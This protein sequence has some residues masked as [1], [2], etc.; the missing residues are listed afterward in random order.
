MFRHESTHSGYSPSTAP[1]ANDTLLWQWAGYGVF[2]PIVVDGKVITATSSAVYALD[3]TTGVQVWGPTTLGGSFTASP[4]VVGDRLYL[5]TSAGFMYCINA[6]TGEE[7]WEYQVTSP[8]QIQASPTVANG[9]VYFGTTN[10][11][12]YALD[13][14]TGLYKWRYTTGNSIY[15]S[16]PAVEGTMIYFGCDDGKLYAINDTGTLPQKKWDFPTKGAIECTPMLADGKVFCGSSYNDHALFAL[17]KT[18]G[19][20]IWKF[21]TTQSYAIDQPPAFANGLVFF[22]GGYNKAYALYSNATAGNY[23]ENDPA[24]QLWGRTTDYN[25][26]P[27]CVADN[28]VFVCANQDLFALNMST[29]IPIWK[30]NFATSAYHAVV[31]DGRLFVNSYNGIICFGNPFPPETYHY[32]VNAGG[33][34]W[35]VKLVLNATPSNRLNTGGLITLKK[36]SYNVTGISGTVGMSNITIPNA[37]LGGPYTVTVDGGLPSYSAAPVDNGTHTSLYFTYDHSTHLIEIT[38]TTVIPEA[39]PWAILPLL[40]ATSLIAF[41]IKKKK[42]KP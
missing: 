16:S 11:Y 33:Q 28:K 41:A 35:D 5:G 14:I 17:D 8:G 19:Q 1:N 22:S 3:E 7:I 25:G 34:D 4:T 10:N 24:I 15:S 31:A 26:H 2:S 13:A 27:P 20:L 21:E 39:T 29:G 40:A 42:L 37:L 32:T 6:T 9:R 18:S 36:I 38:G 23:T 30:Y 12:L